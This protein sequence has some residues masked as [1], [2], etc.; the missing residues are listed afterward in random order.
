MGAQPLTMA[1]RTLSPRAT[2]LLAIGLFLLGSLLPLRLTRWV[3]WLRDPLM[4]IVA[5]IS[6][7]MSALSGW[8][9]PGRSP[10]HADESPELADLRQQRDYYRG[11]Y[12]RAEQENAQLRD[13][14]RALQEGVAYGAPAAV[15][16]LA[17][18]RI[19]ADPGAGTIDVSRGRSHGVTLATVAVAVN[20][21]QHLVGRVSNT[22]SMVSTVQLITDQ[23]ISPR[24][25]DALIIPDGEVTPERIASAPRCQFE[26]DGE[27]TLVAE[28]GALH[29][30]QIE[31]GD[32]AF[33]DDPHWPASAQRLIVGRVVRVEETDR[34]LFRRVVI[35]PDFEPARVTSVI[36]RIAAEE[37]EGGAEGGRQ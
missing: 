9:R 4:T 17:A 22:E 24:L 26:P 18:S 23:R 15:R 8:L 21:P 12:F 10:E 29:A 36:L 20:A 5:P 2:L 33:L 28:L 32:L 7:P 16:R 13:T 25:I 6:G 37:G 14:V 1:R 27:G 31:K 3:G 30:D 19:G 35:R 11:A 34:P